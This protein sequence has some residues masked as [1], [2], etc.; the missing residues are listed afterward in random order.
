MAG[1]GVALPHGYSRA[2]RQI[3]SGI[4]PLT[5][6]AAYAAGAGGGAADALSLL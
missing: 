6:G 1:A 4:T 2:E 3:K 5:I